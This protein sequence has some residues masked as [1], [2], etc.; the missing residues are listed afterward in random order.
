MSQYHKYLRSWTNERN[1]T[2]FLGSEKQ[3]FL[4]DWKD[5]KMKP[6][7]PL[8]E[9]KTEPMEIA[10]PTVSEKV[11]P[12]ITIAP[13]KPKL[14]SAG[15][16]VLNNPDLMRLI[17]G[18][19]PTDKKTYR[20]EIDGEDYLIKGDKIARYQSGVVITDKKKIALLF[21]KL[22][23]ARIAKQAGLPIPEKKTR[24]PSKAQ[25]DKRLKEELRRREMMERDTAQ[26]GL[27]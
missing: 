27:Y 15:A 4:A 6:V 26:G 2:S 17:E 20:V 19:K 11:S 1:I 16:K 13:R 3:E 22:S 23:A 18:F 12:K 24:K 5:I 10:E 8:I 9:V 21:K 14:E 25:E 7:R